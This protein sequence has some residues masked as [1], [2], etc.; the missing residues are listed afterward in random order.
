MPPR[1]LVDPSTLL[2]PPDGPCYRREDDSYWCDCARLCSG[3]LQPVHRNAWYYHRSPEAQLQPRA[4]GSRTGSRIAPTSGRNEPGEASQQG[5]GSAIGLGSGYIDNENGGD[6]GIPEGGLEQPEFQAAE[7]SLPPT[8]AAAPAMQQGVA[9]EANVDNDDTP[10]VPDPSSG[11]APPTVTLQDIKDALAY[12]EAL[13]NA[14]LDGLPDY[15][16]QRLQAPIRTVLNLDSDPDTK[17]CIRLFITVGAASQQSYKDA[18]AAIQEHFPQMKLLTYEEVQSTIQELTGIVPIVNDMCL[19]S[20]MACTGPLADLQQCCKCSEPRYDPSSLQLVPRAQFYTIPIGPQFQALWRNPESA[21]LM[22]YRKT[23][24]AEMRKKVTVNT[25]GSFTVELDE[26]NDY[27]CGTDYIKAVLGDHITDDD[28]VL[29]LSADG[30]QLYEHKSSDC[31][32]YIWVVM[33]LAPGERYK[34]RHVIPAAFIPG[35][36]NPQNYDSFTFPSLYHLAGLQKHGL[37]IWD[38]REDRLFRSYLYLLFVTS[39]G[40][41]LIHFNG[42]NGHQGYCGCR[43]FCPCLGRRIDNSTTYYPVLLRPL[44]DLPEGS[45]HPDVD[46]GDL[47]WTD[48]EAIYK[49][50]LKTLVSAR[51]KSQYKVIRRTTGISKP[52]IISGLDPTRR[53]GIPNAF[54]NDTMHLTGLNVPQLLLSLW[55]GTMA[56]HSDDDKSTWDWRTL[57]CPTFPI[58]LQWSP[59]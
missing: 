1:R 21:A 52:S 5:N 10:P 57:Q 47:L 38:S 24:T 40:P 54:P 25:D 8:Q 23:A 20:C 12:A 22:S 9:P 16:I 58:G 29:M 26:I 18:C 36:N 7:P 28:C 50:R 44:G 39:D 53:L 59:L 15:V 46:I 11:S 37:V 34:K 14:K 41:G 48:R 2:P 33:D 6:G 42:F 17:L 30:A 51:N 49:E 27:I 13:K 4:R 32:V 3:V 43:G 45:G 31:W 35:P 55:H 19:N 56:C